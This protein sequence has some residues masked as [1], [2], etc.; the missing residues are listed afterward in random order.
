MP[1]AEKEQ[2]ILRLIEFSSGIK[3]IPPIPGDGAV[4]SGAACISILD[5]KAIEGEK[6]HS[7]AIEA[8]RIALTPREGVD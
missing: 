8:W 2:N 7:Q 5:G 3:S 6:A 1:F 4:S